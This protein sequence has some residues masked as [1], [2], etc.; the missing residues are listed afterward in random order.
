M[1]ANSS[2]GPRDTPAADVA[3]SMPAPENARSS[4]AT[5]IV[6]TTVVVALLAGAVYAVASPMGSGHSARSSLAPQKPSRLLS[7]RS[8]VARRTVL[9]GSA[10]AF[11]IRISRGRALIHPSGAGRH[12]RVARVWLSAQKPLPARISATFAPRVAFASKSTLTLRA[13]SGA[14]AGTYRIRLNARVRVR[15]VGQHQMRYARTVVTLVVVPLRRFMIRGTAA[16]LLAPG[17]GA[18]IDLRLTNPHRFAI[19][20]RRITVSIGSVRAP[21]ATPARPCSRADFSVVQASRVAGKGVPAARTRS[22]SALRIPRDSWPR[23]AMID[24]TVNQDGC[25]RASVTL[26]YSGSAGKGPP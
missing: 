4:R 7:I 1:A 25:K 13:N 6:V 26:R 15:P 9:P 5:Q 22:L 20:V 12:P 24:R 14:R 10:V 2:A 11:G 18:P 3:G 16:G 8:Q 19:S 17:V 21:Q 23:V